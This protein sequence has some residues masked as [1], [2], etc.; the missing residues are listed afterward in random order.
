MDVAALGRCSSS[1]F[2]RPR[3]VRGRTTSRHRHR[4]GTRRS[5]PCPGSRNDLVC[6]R[7]TELGP[8]GHDPDRRLCGIADPPRGVLGRQ[9]GLRVR[10]VRHRYG[11]D[12][13]RPRVASALRASRNQGVERSRR[14][15]RS[16]D[17]LA[18]ACCGASSGARHRDSCHG[19]RTH[20]GRHSGAGGH[21]GNPGGHPGNPGGHPGNPGTRS[22]RC[23]SRRHRHR[24]TPGSRFGGD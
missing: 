24:R 18:T 11:G 6:G 15:R 3:P 2:P 7:G 8:H 10:G 12:E 23:A 1:L 13:R 22:V 14:L 21:P 17:P 19:S 5:C 9:G 4:G 20:A 16:G